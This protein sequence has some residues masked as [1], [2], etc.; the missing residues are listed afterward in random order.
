MPLA[1]EDF[2]HPDGT[3]RTRITSSPYCF[4]QKTGM[5]NTSTN[6]STNRRRRVRYYDN[7]HDRP[8]SVRCLHPLVSTQAFRRLRFLH[9]SSAAQ[10]IDHSKNKMYYYRSGRILFLHRDVQHPPFLSS[11]SCLHHHPFALSHLPWLHSY[12]RDGVIVAHMTQLYVLCCLSRPCNRIYL[13]Y[14]ISM[15]IVR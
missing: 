9:I 10:H 6:Q 5:F 12:V 13:R 4:V 11:L 14:L 1:V 3:D 2:F 15:V 8:T 7:K